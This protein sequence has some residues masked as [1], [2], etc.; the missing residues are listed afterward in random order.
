MA[1]VVAAEQTETR[2]AARFA[3]EEKEDDKRSIFS[4]IMP[5]PEQH[6]ARDFFHT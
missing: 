1:V 6:R 2:I 4:D 3:R 5:D